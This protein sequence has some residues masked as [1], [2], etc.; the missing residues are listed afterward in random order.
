MALNNALF[1]NFFQA[2]GWPVPADG[3]VFGVG[4]RGAKLLDAD[5]IELEPNR[6]GFQNDVL[7]WAGAAWFLAEGTV[8]PGA[9]PA[10]NPAGMAYRADGEHLFRLGTHKK[11]RAF[12]QHGPARIWR[13]VDASGTQGPTE[14]VHTETGNGLNYHAGSLT[15]IVG[16]NSYGCLN[17]RG[18]YTGA[19]WKKIYDIGKKAISLGQCKTPG[20]LAVYLMEGKQLVEFSNA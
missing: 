8:E 4:I 20:V 12:V 2:K 10:P 14:E 19:A 7:G 16:K 18:G 5:S 9:V 13:D 3:T 1:R 6:R 17:I 11:H 15:D